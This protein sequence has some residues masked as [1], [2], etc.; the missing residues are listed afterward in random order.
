MDRAKLTD[1]ISDDRLAEIVKAEREGRLK[2]RKRPPEATCG[3]CLHFLRNPG[4]AGGKCGKRASVRKG[5]KMKYIVKV[6]DAETG[7][8]VEY[9]G[10]LAEFET[11]GCLIL[12]QDGER[13]DEE[14]LACV[15]FY[16]PSFVKDREWAISQL[17]TNLVHFCADVVEGPDADGF[18]K[19]RINKDLM[20]YA[21]ICLA[22]EI[23]RKMDEDEAMMILDDMKKAVGVSKPLYGLFNLLMGALEHED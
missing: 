9:D 16:I 10:R 18:L 7:T 8:P 4:K 2:F 1:F 21:A 17:I 15:G 5:T 19:A 22:A 23:G 6:I 12:C 3:S 13:K 14:L 11:N 20:H